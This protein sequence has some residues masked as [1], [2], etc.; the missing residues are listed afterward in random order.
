MASFELKQ[1]SRVGAPAGNY[2]VRV[3]IEETSLPKTRGSLRKLRS[4]RG[5]SMKTHRS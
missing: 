4:H 1:G 3:E 2:L 5:I